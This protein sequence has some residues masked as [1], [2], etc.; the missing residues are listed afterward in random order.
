MRFDVFFNDFCG[1]LLLEWPCWYV[2]ATFGGLLNQI[3]DMFALLLHK[4]LMTQLAWVMRF[5]HLSTRGNNRCCFFGGWYGQ[6]VIHTSLTSLL[7]T[8]PKTNS[9][10]SLF[11]SKRHLFR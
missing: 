8:I 3:Q 9:S 7:I 10:W 6:T 1:V 2:S 11:C 5:L 4:V